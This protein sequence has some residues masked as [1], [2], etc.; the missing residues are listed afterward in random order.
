MGEGTVEI[1]REILEEMESED[2][3]VKG[4]WYVS[5]VEKGVIRCND[6]SV[7]NGHYFRGR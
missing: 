7:G 5:K 1:M 2:N 6:S 3:L 4:S